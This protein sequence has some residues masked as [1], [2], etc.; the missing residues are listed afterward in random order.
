MKIKHFSVWLI[1]IIILLF[2]AG[3][4][5]YKV[6]KKQDQNNQK[7]LYD[8][9]IN[10]LETIDVLSMFNETSQN[11]VDMIEGGDR[12]TTYLMEL[13]IECSRLIEQIRLGENLDP[14]QKEG[15][16]E[17]MISSLRPEKVERSS[18]ISKKQND[19]NMEFLNTV[20]ENFDLQ[21]NT[22]LKEIMNEEKIV[23]ENKIITLNYYRLHTHHFLFSL[24]SVFVEP[25]E[26]LSNNNRE[27]LVLVTK[28]IEKSILPPNKVVDE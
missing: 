17:L 9:N 3:G 18:A 13:T 27:Y 28:A 25:S 8:L 1:L 19:E 5:V 22:L 20:K 14:I 6:S 4:C 26:Y 7:Y 11:M 10:L 15:Q 21:L 24:L 12:Y 16:I 2:I 23:Q